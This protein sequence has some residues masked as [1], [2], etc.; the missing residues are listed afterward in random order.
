MLLG[1]C[2]YSVAQNGYTE[3][4]YL[5]NGSIIRGIVIE[6]V[7]NVSL[8]IKTADGSI[9][10]YPMADVEKIVKEETVITRNNNYP[11]SS[12]NANYYNE[13][14][15]ARKTLRGYKGFVDLG[16]LFD[17]SD[18]NANKFE[19]S[20][21]HG[22]QINN[23]FF[24]GGGLALDCFTDR[25]AVSIPVFANFRANFINKKITPF[26]DFK[27]GYAAGD[28]EGAYMS[29]AIGARFG[30]VKK[31]ALNLR[32]EYSLQ[33]FDDEYYYYYGG[34]YIESGALNSIGLKI[35]FEF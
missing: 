32:L 33:G 7:P 26:G 11:A 2:T 22:Y 14:R 35:G 31:M 28:L 4:V 34:Y 5:K 30:L 25:D 17:V 9:F 6:Q 27:F 21:T 15:Q 1:I 3:V 8:K 12:Y 18:N 23:Y 13:R 24:V 10:A 20:T 19:I 16:Y 29:M